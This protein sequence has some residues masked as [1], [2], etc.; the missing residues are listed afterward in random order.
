MKEDVNFCRK[1]MF[2]KT[3]FVQVSRSVCVAHK[4]T[5][6]LSQSAFHESPTLKKCIQSL[7]LTCDIDTVLLLQ[8][9]KQ[10]ALLNIHWLP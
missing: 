3:N 5:F 10:K 9:L 1:K 8:Q 2:A 4:F 6:Q 7:K